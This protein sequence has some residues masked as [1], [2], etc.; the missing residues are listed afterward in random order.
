[1]DKNMKSVLICFVLVLVLLIPGQ[2][3]FAIDK[4]EETEFA[5]GT[6][7]S[8]DIPSGVVVIKEQNYDTGI[9]A[10]VTYYLGPDTDYENIDSISEIALGNDV[11]ISYIVKEDA[12]KVIRFI[13]VYEPELEAEEE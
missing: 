9:E 3:S 4:A 12:K 1:M 2:T 5:Y 7:T 11:D 8:V 6:V 10:D 13:S